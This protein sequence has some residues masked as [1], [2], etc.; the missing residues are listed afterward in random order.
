MYYRSQDEFLN[1]SWSTFNII[2]ASTLNY[3]FQPIQIYTEYYVTLP[4]KLTVIENI[5]ISRE[6]IRVC[7]KE[8]CQTFNISGEKR[9]IHYSHVV[10]YFNH[11]LLK[12][13]PVENAGRFYYIHTTMYVLLFLQRKVLIQHK[14]LLAIAEES[15]IHPMSFNKQ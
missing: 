12:V 1:L 6:S 10:S 15:N 5:Q 2:I 13:F 7:F 11:V 8:S 4:L 9:V 14:I 3:I